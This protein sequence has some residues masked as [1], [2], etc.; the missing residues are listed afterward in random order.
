MFGRK[1]ESD[2]CGWV[3]ASLV[4]SVSEK[5]PKKTE[6]SSRIVEFKFGDKVKIKQGAKTY[7]GGRLAIGVFRI[8]GHFLFALDRIKLAF[9]Y[10]DLSVSAQKYFNGINYIR[11]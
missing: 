2:V 11:L 8:R 6:Q 4:E 3:D 1:G 9:F 5:S 10:Y 7:R